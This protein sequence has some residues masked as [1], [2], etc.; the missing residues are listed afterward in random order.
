MPQLFHF[1]RNNCT[2]KIILPYVSDE[3]F[4]S[5]GTVSEKPWW[6]SGNSHRTD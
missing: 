2:N 1:D 3:L 5:D 4:N 6:L